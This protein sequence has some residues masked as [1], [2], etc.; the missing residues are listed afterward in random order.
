MTYNIECKTGGH[1]IESLLDEAIR[2]TDPI[3]VLLQL[4][5]YN[6]DYEIRMRNKGNEG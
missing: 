6:K 5:K 1:E 4:K 2:Q 3:T